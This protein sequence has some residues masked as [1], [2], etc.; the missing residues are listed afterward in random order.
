MDVLVLEH[1]RLPSPERFNDIANTPLWSCLMAGYTCSALREAGFD[2][3]LM[4]A[5][6]MGF[7]EVLET[8]LRLNPA[9]LA[10]HAVYFW[11]HTPLLFRF[12]DDLKSGG[13]GGVVCLFG[14]FPSLVWKEL[15]EAYDAVDL[16]WVGEPEL[17]AIEAVRRI[18]SGL[19]PEG[20]G[21]AGRKNGEPYLD[22]VGTP[23]P[24][25]DRLPEPVRPGLDSEDT[26][27]VLASRGCY[28]GCSFCLIPALNG[29]KTLWRGRSPEGVIHEITNLKQ[30]GKRDFYF[31]DPNF[32]GPGRRGRERGM[33]IARMLASPGVTWGMETRADDLTP[34]V[35]QE[36]ADCGL[37]SLLIGLESGSRRVLERLGK[38]T[39]TSDNLKAV[40]TVRN[41][42][43]EPEV[44][45]IM[46]ERTSS[47]AQIEENLSFLME[48]GLLDRLG[49]TANLLYHD[50]I[51]LKGTR[52]YE[53]AKAEGKLRPKGVAGFE[54]ELFYDDPRVRWLSGAARRLCLD[55]LRKMGGPGKLLVV[56]AG[57]YGR[58]TASDP[59]PSS[60][61]E[62]PRDARLGRQMAF[63]TGS[64]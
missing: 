60:R 64:P 43:L 11:E 23:P 35:M 42:G 19:S 18:L 26:V 13:Y 17:T 62:V 34:E 56:G 1:P 49:R 45:F 7:S 8:V 5:R 57:G 55:V 33:R 41:A 39:D 59:Q 58:R 46:F 14:F 61:G 6:R 4:D 3:D 40:E 47:L 28:N 24:V 52:L 16:I 63:N 21:C 15:L 25:L 32:F 9:I 37:T 2:V 12:L 54:G 10:V 50:Q 30:A 51:A 20:P 27:S 31:V 48:A 29:G 38:N 22:Q 36:L 53:Q 44:G